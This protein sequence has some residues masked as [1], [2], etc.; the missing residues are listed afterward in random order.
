VEPDATAAGLSAVG[1]QMG[2]EAGTSS[3]QEA[4][5]RLDAIQHLVG[6][7][8]DIPTAVRD[9]ARYVLRGEWP[10]GPD[11]QAALTALGTL[12]RRGPVGIAGDLAT[13]YGLT[14][15]AAFGGVANPLAALTRPIA[16]TAVGG[17]LDALEGNATGGARAALERARQLGPLGQLAIDAL[18]P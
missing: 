16:E 2:Q 6:D 15:A 10:T 12:A 7:A 18:N 3:R 17:T 5:A 11:L 8:A 4:Q 13:R 14:P 9:A 1:A